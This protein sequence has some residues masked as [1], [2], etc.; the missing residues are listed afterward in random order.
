VTL[1]AGSLR[2]VSDKSVCLVRV[3]SDAVEFEDFPMPGH[4]TADKVRQ[5]RSRD[6]SLQSVSLHH[7][8]RDGD[9]PAATYI[10]SIDQ[11]MRGHHHDNHHNNDDNDDVFVTSEELEL[12]RATIKEREK[13][14]LTAADVILCTC[15]ESVAGRLTDSTNIIQVCLDVCLSRVFLLAN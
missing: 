10:R 15:V 6:L 13:E 8:I 11:R 4:V 3:Y 2:S 1:H 5:L 7:L 12:Y 14:L 9:S